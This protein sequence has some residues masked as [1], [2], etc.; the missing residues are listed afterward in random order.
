MRQAASRR[1]TGPSAIHR[2]KRIGRVLVL[3]VASDGEALRARRPLQP[4]GQWPRWRAC[5]RSIGTAHWLRGRAAASRSAARTDCGR[6][7]RRRDDPLRAWRYAPTAGPPSD[8]RR[9][10]IATSRGDANGRCSMFDELL[11]QPEIVRGCLDAIDDAIHPAAGAEGDADLHDQPGEQHLFRNAPQE[12]RHE[13]RRQ[14]SRPQPQTPSQRA[15]RGAD[16]GRI[17]AQ[18]IQRARAAD[19]RFGREHG[20]RLAKIDVA[21]QLRDRRVAR[22]QSRRSAPANAASRPASPRRPR[23]A[24]CRGAGTASR[25]RT[26]R[27]PARR[28]D[29]REIARRQA[30]C[31]PTSR[32]DGRARARTA[33]GAP[34]ALVPL[35]HAGVGDDE[36]QNAEPGRERARAA[37]QAVARTPARR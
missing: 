19:V 25:A 6:T 24:P 14:W 5:H 7:A 4:R 26:D 36:R 32:R 3:C 2:W 30:R 10:W 8:A 21:R 35:E 16:P 11:E 15:E 17:R 22:A 34:A 18:S 27:G 33:A 1:S 12:R 28:D 31:R 13:E 37:T 9:M 29:R 23:S 20:Q